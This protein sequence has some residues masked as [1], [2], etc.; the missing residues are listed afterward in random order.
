[1]HSDIGLRINDLYAAIMNIPLFKL[2]RSGAYFV[3]AK[4][5]NA[6]IE[7]VVL[8]REYAGEGG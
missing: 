5:A 1:M 8:I 7:A 2:N 6:L 4:M 3:R